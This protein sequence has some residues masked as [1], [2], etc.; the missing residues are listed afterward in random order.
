[1]RRLVRQV[2]VL[3]SALFLGAC[4]SSGAATGGEADRPTPALDE[5]AIADACMEARE[6]HRCQAAASAEGMMFF[7][8]DCEARATGPGEG[9]LTLTG[10]DE[11]EGPVDADFTL[12]WVDGAWQLGDV[13]ADRAR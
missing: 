5:D 11:D 6:H 4:A 7:S 1:M 10:T 3:S 2:I 13:T 9:A 8:C 12:R